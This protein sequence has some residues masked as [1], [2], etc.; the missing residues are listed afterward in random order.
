MRPPCLP[1]GGDSEFHIKWFASACSD[2]CCTVVFTCCVT[3]HQLIEVF[4]EE[5]PQETVAGQI[6]EC[7]MPLF[8]ACRKR[9]RI[10]TG[11]RQGREMRNDSAEAAGESRRATAA[12]Q[13][14]KESRKNFSSRDVHGLDIVKAVPK[15]K[16]PNYAK[17]IEARAAFQPAAT[18]SEGGAERVHSAHPAPRRPRRKDGQRPARRARL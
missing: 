4:R 13:R 8:P 3:I 7:G 18:S 14:D 11:G 16:L 6:Q 12:L 17:G 2:A 9:C 5:P 15:T 1:A 10:K